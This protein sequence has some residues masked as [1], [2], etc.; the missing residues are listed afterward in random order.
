MAGLC[1]K[2]GVPFVCCWRQEDRRQEAG[3]AMFR[4]FLWDKKESRR[5]F[6]LSLAFEGQF[7]LLCQEAAVQGRLLPAYLRCQLN[8]DICLWC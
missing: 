5:Q 1:R 4:G 6:R 8:E 2:C 7:S 3:K